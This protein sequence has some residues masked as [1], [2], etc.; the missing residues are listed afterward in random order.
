MGMADIVPGV[1]GGTVA[2]VLGIYQRLITAVS[3]FDFQFFR[4]VKQRN[5]LDAAK[6]VDLWF[7]ANLASGIVGGLVF[8]V[9]TLSRLLSDETTRPFVMASFFGLVVGS[10]WIVIRMIQMPQAE[11]QA[12]YRSRQ[13]K[14]GGLASSPLEHLNW[15]ALLVGAVIAAVICWMAPGSGLNQLALWY[16]FLCGTV[17]ICAMILPGI[18]GALILLLLGAY[19]HV[20]DALKAVLHLEALGE[21]LL[22]VIVF[23]SGCLIGLLTFS[24]ILRRLLEQRFATTMSLLCGLMVG[25]LFKLWP[26]QADTTPDV[27]EFKLKVFQP[28]MPEKLDG[29]FLAL[30]LTAV[31]AA[32]FVLTAHRVAHRVSARSSKGQA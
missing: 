10:I 26:Y 30:I 31:I 32:V 9:L 24:K 21:N 15:P 6:H 5:F 8:T 2:L 22:I 3:K 20:V 11:Q 29:T 27:E 17:A 16:V 23:A 7:L 19:A 13:I 4:L 14:Q 25:S 1:S 12:K 28:S 18:S